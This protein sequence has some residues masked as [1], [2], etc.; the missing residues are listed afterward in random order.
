M[1]GTT[2]GTKMN[3]RRDLVRE[4]GAR[5]GLVVFEGGGGGG[6]GDVR[7]LISLI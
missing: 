4:A 6:S 1:N 2:Q 5:G 7:G 3:G